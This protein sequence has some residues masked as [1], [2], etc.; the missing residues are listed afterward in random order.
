MKEELER[1]KDVLRPEGL[2]E[3]H[4][5]LRVYENIAATTR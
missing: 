3:Y 5:A 4:N 2:N 1:N